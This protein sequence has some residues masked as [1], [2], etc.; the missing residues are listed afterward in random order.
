MVMSNKMRAGIFLSADLIL[1]VLLS[2]LSVML[3]LSFVMVQ[4]LVQAACYP[5]TIYLHRYLTHKG[6]TYLHPRIE[7]GCKFLIWMLTSIDWREWKAV[8]L[9]HHAFTDEEGD[10][11]SP[12]LLGWVWVQF[13]NVVEYSREAR[14]P[15]T[16]QEY[17]SDVD[18]YSGIWGRFPFSVNFMGPVIGLVLLSALMG[19]AWVLVTPGSQ[20]AAQ[21]ALMGI[22]WGVPTGLA[23]GFFYI[24][25]SGSVNSLC[26]WFGYR[27]FENTATNLRWVMWLTGGE[28]LHNN[29]HGYPRSA[30]FSATDEEFDPAFP[31]IAWWVEKG[32]ARVYASA[33]HSMED[34]AARQPRLPA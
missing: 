30:R 5:T 34:K 33:I 12:H 29:H 26:H 14:N 23:H 8:H 20:T 28:G 10:P 27:N 32:W 21:W 31:I 15:E 19:T 24:M 25:L 4:V 3:A 13:M 7:S 22:A 6:I 16:L 9:K 2:Q 17:A 11:H 18:R 1:V